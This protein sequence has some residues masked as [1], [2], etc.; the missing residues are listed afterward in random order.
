M[1]MTK[2]GFLETL[3]AQYKD[4]IEEALVESEHVY[5]LTIDYEILDQKISQLVKSAKIDGF[6]EKILWDLIQARIPSYVNYINFKVSG[7]KVA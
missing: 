1:S 6:D 2:E 4:E 5:R 3:I 7:K